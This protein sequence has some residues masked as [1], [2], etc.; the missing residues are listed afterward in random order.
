ML[1]NFCPDA[2][3]PVNVRSSEYYAAR[4]P[5]SAPPLAAPQNATAGLLGAMAG[6]GG[7]LRGGMEIRM[8]LI[9]R[10][11]QCV[12]LELCAL[13]TVRPAP[14]RGSDGQRPLKS[15]S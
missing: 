1:P 2:L 10:G 11:G 15:R 8:I 12:W 9:F 13:L 5:L 14:I 3:S 6:Q 4:S 7:R